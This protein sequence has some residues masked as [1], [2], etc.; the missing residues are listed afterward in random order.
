MVKINLDS[1]KVL[2]IGIIGLV[3]VLGSGV[4]YYNSSQDLDSIVPEMIE[5]NAGQ[6]TK[7]NGEISLDYDIEISKYEVTFEKYLAY[8]KDTDS[9]IPDDEGWGRKK[10]PVTN[11]SWYDAVKYCNWLSEQEGL[12]P[13]YDIKGAKESWKLKDEP[14][15]L[16][17]YRL[18]TE[19]EWSYVARGGDS[20]KTTVYAG[21]NNLEDVGWY[22]G[23][24]DERTH[25]VG[26]KEPNELGVHDMTGNLWEWTTTSEGDKYVQCG[27]SYTN[28]S[29]FCRLKV[30]S[31]NKPS[32]SQDLGIRVVRSR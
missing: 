12:T 18:A 23:N 20:G 7:D 10:R 30:R 17:G 29:H 16:E 1:F 14:Q 24:S 2:I 5:V 28:V 22:D 19:N 8:C 31:L 11:I 25:P 9:S 21:S 13:A 6:T 3:L 26:E 27:G 4:I 15:K 32:V